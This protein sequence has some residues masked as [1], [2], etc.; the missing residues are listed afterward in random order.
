[1]NTNQPESGDS[2]T[3]LLC[4]GE[5]YEIIDHERGQMINYLRITGRGLLIRG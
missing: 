1:M 4:K 5:V 2:E 3:K